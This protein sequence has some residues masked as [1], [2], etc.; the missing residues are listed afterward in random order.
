MAIGHPNASKL[1]V[2]ALLHSFM[3]QVTAGKT[4]DTW[5]SASYFLQHT[6]SLVKVDAAADGTKIN[7]DLSHATLRDSC[8]HLGLA[9]IPCHANVQNVL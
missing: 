8:C 7:P 4:L 9:E 1:R 2:M 6:S 3:K 5:C